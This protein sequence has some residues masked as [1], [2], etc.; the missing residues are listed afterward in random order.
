MSPALS[1]AFQAVRIVAVRAL[2]ATDILDLSAGSNAL[3]RRADREWR[4]SLL[5]KTDFPETQAVIG[6][7]ALSIRNVDAAESAF[8]EAVRQDLQ[9]VQA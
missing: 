3:L 2:L 6:G 8:K 9:L 7:L 4:Q 1:D 5:V